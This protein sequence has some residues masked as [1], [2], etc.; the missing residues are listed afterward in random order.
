MRTHRNRLATTAASS[1]TA[2]SGATSPS[3]P[4]G[5]NGGGA[6]VLLDVD[7][8]GLL[9]IPEMEAAVGDGLLRG[10]FGEDLPGH[11]T[12]SRGGDVGASVVAISISDP[13]VCDALA[14]A[15]E[16]GSTDAGEVVAIGGGAVVAPQ[17][18][19]IDVLV[20]DGCL[21]I[22]GSSRGDS[23]GRDQLV[24]LATAAVGRVG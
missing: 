1:A 24:A 12:Y 16:A 3:T 10:G 4:D 7:P 8:C 21:A 5:S 17:A 13:L 19:H 2:V 14:K 6:H 20:G 11:C 18:G 15:V 23:L 9:T 22:S